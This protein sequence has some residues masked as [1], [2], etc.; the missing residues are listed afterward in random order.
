MFFILQGGGRREDTDTPEESER[1]EKEK[2]G[3]RERGEM[4]ALLNYDIY[5]CGSSLPM[6]DL[7]RG[8]EVQKRGE[9]SRLGCVNVA[10]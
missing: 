2:E 6:G 10:F 8:R 4:L 7:G 1:R 9:R 5:V 3:G